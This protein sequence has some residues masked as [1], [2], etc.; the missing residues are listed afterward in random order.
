MSQ[1]AAKYDSCTAR[2][3]SGRVRFRTSGSFSRSRGW[4]A[5]RSPRKSASVRPRF[6][7]RTPQAPSSTR[8]RSSAAFL[9][10]AATSL[11]TLCTSVCLKGAERS[12]LARLF[13]RLVTRSPSCLQSSPGPALR[14]LAISRDLSRRRRRR[15][16]LGATGDGELV[17]GVLEPLL[18]LLAG[19]DVVDLRRLDRVVDQGDRPV[20]QHLEEPRAGGVLLDVAARQVDPRRAG[21]Q[22]RDQRRVPRQHADL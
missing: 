15:D 9:I 11:A 21:L 6:C 19:A 2:T 10:S 8:M 1:P 5:K 18:D 17:L 20:A 12:R 7:R 14:N 13:R 22:R 16:L 4:E 3:M